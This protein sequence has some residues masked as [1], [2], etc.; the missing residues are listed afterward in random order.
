MKRIWIKW[1]NL[2]LKHHVVLAMIVLVA[3]GIGY[4]GGGER[5]RSELWWRGEQGGGWTSMK[6]TKGKQ[7]EKEE[8]EKEEEE[9]AMELRTWIYIFSL[10]REMRNWYANLY[11]NIKVAARVSQRI[12]TAKGR[13]WQGKLNGKFRK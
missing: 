13:E 12:W 10:K 3:C 1:H 7:N 6:K 8:K 4:G 5:M 9:E 2:G 11:V